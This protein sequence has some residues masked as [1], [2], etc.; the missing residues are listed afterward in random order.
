MWKEQVGPIVEHDPVICVETEGNLRKRCD[1]FEYWLRF[2]QR[3][4]QS[5][6]SLRR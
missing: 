6:E 4:S 5:D 3:R 1:R 2:V